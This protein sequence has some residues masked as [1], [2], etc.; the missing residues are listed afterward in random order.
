MNTNDVMSKKIESKENNFINGNKIYIID[1]RRHLV[2]PGVEE[3][4]YV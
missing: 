3:L 4:V 1:N 2:S